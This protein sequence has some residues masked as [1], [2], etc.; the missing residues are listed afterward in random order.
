M[1]AET[2]ARIVTDT[3][4]LEI[5][6]ERGRF[7]LFSFEVR[8]LFCQPSRQLLNLVSQSFD[9]CLLFVEQ[10]SRN[11]GQSAFKRTANE[12][13]HQGR[14]Q[15]HLSRLAFPVLRLVHL[16]PPFLRHSLHLFPMNLIPLVQVRQ[17]LFN[18]ALL[19]IESSLDIFEFER[20]GRGAIA[21]GVE[22]L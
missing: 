4:L 11:K 14:D 7:G 19:R 2:A 22:F 12:D 9:V 18:L 21:V 15:T 13:P 3:H 10:L 16:L 8:L 17:Q 20:E 5:V 6:S 1:R